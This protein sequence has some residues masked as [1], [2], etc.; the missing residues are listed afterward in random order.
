[1][2]YTILHAT[3]IITTPL[4]LFFTVKRLPRV[5]LPILF[6]SVR[7][8]TYIYRV[9][10]IF[11]FT[12][13]TPL[14][15]LLI[16]LSSLFYLA[17]FIKHLTHT[18]RFSQFFSKMTTTWFWWSKVC[19]QQLCCYSQQ[20][21]SSNRFSPDSRFSGTQWPDVCPDSTWVFLTGTSTHIL[22]NGQL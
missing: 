16:S 9:K 21:W 11:F 22:A 2:F 1:M 17:H 6:S 7:V 4:P 15:L 5:P 20:W 13:Y 12:F 8:R 14:S 3:V 18:S 19:N 10:K